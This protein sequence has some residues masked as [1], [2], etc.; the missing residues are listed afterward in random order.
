M[1]GLSDRKIG[2]QFRTIL[3]VK[4]PQRGIAWVVRGVGEDARRAGAAA[5][6]PPQS[7]MLSFSVAVEVFAGGS[8]ASPTAGEC[9]SGHAKIMR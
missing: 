8:A 1:D 7:C 2:A 9:K 5:E 4:G 3:R 6:R